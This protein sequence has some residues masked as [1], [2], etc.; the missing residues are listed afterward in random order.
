MAVIS[1]Y[2]NPAAMYPAMFT[3]VAARTALQAP[4][5]TPPAIA[6]GLLSLP[7][8]KAQG[9]P[10]DCDSGHSDVSSAAAFRPGSSSLSLDALTGLR[11][12]LI[13]GSAPATTGSVVIGSL[14]SGPVAFGSGVVPPRVSV[15]SAEG[16]Q[17]AA[18]KRKRVSQS[19][20]GPVSQP[21]AC[22]SGAPGNSAAKQPSKERLRK[23][24]DDAVP[25]E[26]TQNSLVLALV[27]QAAAIL[28][29]PALVVTPS[30][31]TIS[32]SNS[33]NSATSDTL[34]ATAAATGPIWNNA[35]PGVDLSASPI[36]TGPNDPD[37]DV[38]PAAPG[39]KFPAQGA[40]MKLCLLPWE[41]GA[42]GEENL[43]DEFKPKT[44]TPPTY[45]ERQSGHG[46]SQADPTAAAS[47]KQ[48]HC[49]VSPAGAIPTA[50][51]KRKHK[52]KAVPLANDNRST[53][54][55]GDSIANPTAS[56]NRKGT[57]A[58]STANSS[59][60]ADEPDVDSRETAETT[61]GIKAPA[62]KNKDLQ[63]PNDNCTP[64]ATFPLVTLPAADNQVDA[65]ITDSAS[66]DAPRSVPAP[67]PEPTPRVSLRQS[68]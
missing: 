36:L 60:A 57:L 51:Q 62:A 12:P 19:K 54:D 23:S 5:G 2:E 22:A 45:Q 65:A 1:D 15:P 42:D 59:S 58:I 14:V 43:P 39:T 52:P 31:A 27:E 33:T 44:Y 30:P 11:N 13:A 4:T 49:S 32:D 3:A 6:F 38:Q 17:Q 50:V 64:D 46:M 9:S 10:R 25:R 21:V 61:G 35:A 47:K 8:H 53:K 40:T 20:A 55:T 63:A 68:K 29:V 16:P 18:P 48:R 26:F 67:V 41:V 34:L 28:P 24:F 66:A 37:S 7:D 56:K